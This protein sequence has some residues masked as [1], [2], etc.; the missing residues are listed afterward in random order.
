MSRP[1]FSDFFDRAFRA[2]SPEFQGARQKNREPG[3][4]SLSSKSYTSKKIGI[5]QGYSSG[6][7]VGRGSGKILIMHLGSHAVMQNPPVKTEKVKLY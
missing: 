1:F 3:F 6:V 7:R 5:K 2:L 4:F